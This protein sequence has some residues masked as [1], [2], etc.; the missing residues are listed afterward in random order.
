MCKQ[1]LHCE[2]CSYI[3]PGKIVPSEIIWV[4]S[5]FNYSVMKHDP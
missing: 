1:N 4:K 3:L 2:K 5:V